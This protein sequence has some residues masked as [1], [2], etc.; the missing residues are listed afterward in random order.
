MTN[1]I[2]PIPLIISRLWSFLQHM[3]I[4]ARLQWVWDKL[5][6]T[7]EAYS[8]GNRQFNA[9]SV[10]TVGF[11]SVLLPFNIIM[12]LKEV[13]AMLLL[14]IAIQGACYI[15]GRMFRFYFKGSVP[16][17]VLSYFTLIFVYF[18][19]SGINGPTIFLYFLSFH[20]LIAFSPRKQHLI[21]ALTHAMVGVSLLAIEF[22]N[23]TL[24]PDLYK[25]RDDRFFDIASSYFVTLTVIYFITI[26]LRNQL[27]KKQVLAE[28]AA[29]ELLLKHAE[30]TR[31][32]EQKDKLFSIIAH[33]LRSPVNSL[34][35][36]LELLSEDQLSEEERQMVQHELLMQTQSTSDMLFNLLSWSKTQMEGVKMNIRNLELR[37]VLQKTLEFQEQ[38]AVRKDID[39]DWDVKPGLVVAVDEDM[40]QLVVR[41]L[42]QNAIKFTQ[43]G[44]K[45]TIVS[46]VEQGKCC[47]KV[48]DTG[49]GM[50]AEQQAQIFTLNAGTTSG[51]RQEKG[52]GLGLVLCREFTELQGGSISFSSIPGEGSVFKI[53]LPAIADQ[54][55][56]LHVPAQ[57][58]F[59]GA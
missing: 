5:V 32:N 19:N 3:V 13:S 20:L 22:L 18:F 45:I 57:P 16:Y 56:V 8:E 23:P 15:G 54:A 43:P 48:S 9:I 41:N 36:F 53:C 52:V 25:S 11:L 42:V 34:K 27:T 29:A 7:K 47:I 49:I 46:T 37:G 1:V 55:S 58:C 17:A 6:G 30:L 51:T 2:V 14:L 40:L 33:D 28:N 39:L 21:W 24:I 31:V 12:G 4:G 44:G 38:A 35:S 50:T 59:S 10:I 26:Y